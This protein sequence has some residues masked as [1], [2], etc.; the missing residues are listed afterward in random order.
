MK[1][2]A[3][4]GMG[5]LG[6]G[7]Q[8]LATTLRTAREARTSSGLAARQRA[9]QIAAQESLASDPRSAALLALPQIEIPQAQPIPRAYL[10]VAGLLA[11]GLVGLIIWRS[12]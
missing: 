1:N 7:A 10:L 12:K 8:D 5:G 6:A 11:V 2:R 3:Q 9:A 4:F